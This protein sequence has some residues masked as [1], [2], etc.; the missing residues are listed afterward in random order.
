MQIVNL[1]VPTISYNMLEK[2]AAWLLTICTT[3]LYSKAFKAV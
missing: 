1:G 2:S 3:V